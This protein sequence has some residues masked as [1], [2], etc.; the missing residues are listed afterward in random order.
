AHE[1]YARVSSCTT[2]WIRAHPGPRRYAR[3]ARFAAAAH[4]YGLRDGDLGTGPQSH[5]ARRDQRSAR[6]VDPQFTASFD[7]RGLSKVAQIFNLL[8]RRF[9]IGWPSED[10]RAQSWSGG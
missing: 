9:A 3:D 2:A 6:L 4:R 8:Y 1:Y 5:C 10:Y 7:E